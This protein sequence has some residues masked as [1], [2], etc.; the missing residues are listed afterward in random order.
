LA[1]TSNKL[2]EN[3]HKV[4]CEHE[5]FEGDSA[6]HASKPREENNHLNQEIPKIIGQITDGITN[7]LLYISLLV[8]SII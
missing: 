3:L 5:D 2:E 7:K 1:N 6:Q 8:M 4:L